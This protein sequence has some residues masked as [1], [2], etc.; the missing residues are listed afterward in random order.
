MAF[1]TLRLALVVPIA[2]LA[3]ALLAPAAHA[4]N[5]PA[6]PVEIS[7]PTERDYKECPAAYVCAFPQKKGGG[8]PVKIH[9]N[10]SG[11]HHLDIVAHS[12][13]NRTSKV[14]T[15]YRWKARNGCA[16]P[17]FTL[18]PGQRSDYA[19]GAPMNEE[20]RCIGIP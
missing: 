6:S 8:T 1:T 5:D 18:Q 2:A 7:A 19:G 10:Q 20:V 14:V 17:S 9:Q 11:K 13:Q 3:A 16:R 4:Q 12:V 15:F